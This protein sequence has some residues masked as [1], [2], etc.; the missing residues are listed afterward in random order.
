MKLHL[1]KAL[2]LSFVAAV[3]AG[4]AQAASTTVTPQIIVGSDEALKAA[5]TGTPVNVEQ[6]YTKPVVWESETSTTVSGYDI[7][8][9]APL[10][11]RE[12]DLTIKDSKLNSG[13]I[14]GAI[15][16]WE[17]GRL[18]T[19]NGSEISAVDAKGGVF[20]VGG[21]LDSDGKFTSVTGAAIDAWGD[22]ALTEADF[23]FADGAVIDLHGNDFSFSGGEIC[24]IMQDAAQ[25]VL[26][27]DEGATPY[28]IQGITFNNAGS[29]AGLEEGVTVTVQSASGQTIGSTTLSSSKVRVNNVPEPTTA[30]L[31]LLALAG[32]AARRRRASR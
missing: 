10:Y 18:V 22:I 23:I 25:L 32:L 7:N 26:L 30:T 4:V 12:G 19:L 15:T 8:L 31:S 21:S 13:T 6:K 5:L 28:Q 27:A 9:T 3:T 17:S 11:V 16:L 14:G 29:V 2:I 24:I 1:P 20:Q